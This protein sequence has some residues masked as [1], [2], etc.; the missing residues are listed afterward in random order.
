MVTVLEGLRR[1]RTF[2]AALF[3]VLALAASAE[4]RLSETYFNG[5]GPGSRLENEDSVTGDELKLRL[6]ALAD[7]NPPALP[8]EAE[9]LT[10][11]VSGPADDLVRSS[12]TLGSS[13]RAPPFAV[14]S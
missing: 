1:S 9:A 2:G 7:A 6:I 10:E 13:P 11:A 14:S 12:A 5:T 3:L 8:S 4:R